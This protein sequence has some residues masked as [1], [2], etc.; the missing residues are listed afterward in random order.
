MPEQ[1]GLRGAGSIDLLCGGR[2]ND[3]LT[4]G[5]AADHFDG[6]QGT[7]TTTDYTASKEGTAEPISPET[8]EVAEYLRMPVENM[9]WPRQEGRSRPLRVDTVEVIGVD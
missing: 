6:G 2:G 1:A 4:G 3:R 5:A 7:D 8:D 9:R